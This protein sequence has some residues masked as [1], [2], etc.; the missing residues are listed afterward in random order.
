MDV[1]NMMMMIGLLTGKVKSQALRRWLDGV[2]GILLD[3]DI[4]VRIRI[5]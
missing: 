1:K 3:I 2:S 5:N 4:F